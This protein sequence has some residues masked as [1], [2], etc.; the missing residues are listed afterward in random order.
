MTRD[1]GLLAFVFLALMA[2][3][4]VVALA[5]GD[6]AWIMADRRYVD[7]ANIHCCGP[8][9]CKRVPCAMLLEDRDGIEF[10]GQRLL[11]RERGIYWSAEPN[12]PDGSQDCWACARPT[13]MGGP[14]VLKCLFRPQAGS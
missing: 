6:A 8:T 13:G 12:P 9:D 14:P 3:F 4:A 7:K 11:R 1:A 2:A 5:H 10:E